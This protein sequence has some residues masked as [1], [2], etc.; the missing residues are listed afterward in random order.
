MRATVLCLLVLLAGC[1]SDPNSA[2]DRLGDAVYG[3]VNEV[4][5]GRADLASD[6][7]DPQFRARFVAAHQGWG[8]RVTVAD[9][10]VENLEMQRDERRATAVLAVSWY[11][12][13]AM[14]LRLTRVRQEWRQVNR[15]YVLARERVVSGD[16][17]LLASAE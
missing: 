6:R 11:R 10:D 17:S 7:V 8:E 16:A 13:D 12:S 5:W 4:R 9:C 14:D 3:L 15:T 2:S 1:L